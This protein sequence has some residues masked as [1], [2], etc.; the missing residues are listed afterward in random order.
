MPIREAPCR[1][2]PRA[3]RVRSRAPALRP[4]FIPS[5]SPGS[6]AASPMRSERAIRWRWPSLA[7]LRGRLRRGIRPYRR[8]HGPR[9]GPAGARG[10]PR[11]I[12]RRAGGPLGG[13]DPS[14]RGPGP[15]RR[16]DRECRHARGTEG[17]SR[18]ALRS[19]A[20]VAAAVRGISPAMRIVL[21][22]GSDAK[23]RGRRRSS[24]P[25]SSGPISIS[26]RSQAATVGVAREK[27]REAFRRLERVRRRDSSLGFAAWNRLPG[28]L[29]EVVREAAGLEAVPFPGRIPGPPGDR[30]LRP[31]V[32]IGDSAVHR[33]R[34]N[35]GIDRARAARRWRIRL[36]RDLRARGSDRT[37]AEMTAAGKN[38]ISH[39]RRAWE[40]LRR[41]IRLWQEGR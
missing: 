36:G 30:E 33:D 5:S 3:P 4:R 8:R 18:R 37:F 21:V 34:A 15:G 19:M 29:R 23:A 17:R 32:S 41:M 11:F 9:G 13:A 16:R 40:E 6:A 38:A 39:R 2:E 22:T 24:A 31:R 1:R 20:P 28:P 7:D 25:R 27:A 35:R 14:G 26:P 10:G 12:E